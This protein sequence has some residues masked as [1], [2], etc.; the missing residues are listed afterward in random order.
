MPLQFTAIEVSIETCHDVEIITFAAPPDDDQDL[1]VMF[2]RLQINDQTHSIATPSQT[3]QPSINP[4]K[5]PPEIPLNSS[6]DS[7]LRAEG[8][9]PVIGEPYIE[10][11]SQTFAWFGHLK[12]LKLSEI[13]TFMQTPKPDPQAKPQTQAKLQAQASPTHLQ[14]YLEMDETAAAQMEN[15]GIVLIN[16]SLTDPSLQQLRATLTD[17]FPIFED[18]LF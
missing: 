10:I 12:R 16:F 15:D 9:L 6:L 1:Y 2:Q 13:K 18:Q 5:I 3:L 11:C 17:F 14:L 7:G 8:N 4:P